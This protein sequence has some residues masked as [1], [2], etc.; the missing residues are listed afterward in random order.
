MGVGLAYTGFSEW[1]NVYVRQSWTY[2]ALMPTMAFGTI[3][4]G[5]SPLAQWL[6]IPGVGF[7][8]I[9]YWQR[10]HLKR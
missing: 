4:I 9:Y 7:A 6:I 3:R 2:S 10:M 1:L 5:L 8:T